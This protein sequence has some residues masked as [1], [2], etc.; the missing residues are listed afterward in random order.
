MSEKVKI[1]W[2]VVYEVRRPN[3]Q[4]FVCKGIAHTKKDDQQELY[5]NLKLRAE[6]T[7]HG[8]LVTGLHHAQ[9]VDDDF[10]PPNYSL[11]Q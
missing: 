1:T 4:H 7:E 2:W 10:T 9:I 6:R 11:L 3:G 5:N 8:S